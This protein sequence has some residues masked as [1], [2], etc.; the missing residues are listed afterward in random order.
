VARVKIRRDRLFRSQGAQPP[1][2][3]VR[4]KEIDDV[5][6][7]VTQVFCPN[8]HNL[9]TE[10]KGLFD[11]QPGIWLKVSD[12]T[13]SGEVVLSPFH[14]DHARLGF[15]DFKDGTRVRISCPICDVP[16]PRLSRCSCGQGD[17]VA[18]Y[19]TPSLEEGQVV[20]LCDVWG[21]HRSK[22]FDQA[23]LLSAYLEDDEPPALI[24]ESE[25]PYH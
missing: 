13:R 19:L 5:V 25:V 8:G 24:G 22:V 4:I 23:Q 15:T 17:M 10:S 16:L 21:C 3:D 1:S 18:L 9:V 6:I 7:Q 2:E 11:G 20:A 14:G 12:G